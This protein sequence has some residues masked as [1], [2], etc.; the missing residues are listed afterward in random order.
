[1][2]RDVDYDKA[3]PLLCALYIPTEDE[4]CVMPLRRIVRMNVRGLVEHAGGLHHR[5][6]P[7]HN[8]LHNDPLNSP[9]GMTA[10]MWA[11]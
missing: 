8:Y 4:N 10:K 9:Q 3:V 6:L 2:Q 7:Q 1:M 5:I 11:G